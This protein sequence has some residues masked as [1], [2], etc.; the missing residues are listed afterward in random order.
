MSTTHRM[1][2]MNTTDR[3]RYNLVYVEQIHRYLVNFG[4][5]NEEAAE[6][7][8]CQSSR[9]QSVDEMRGKFQGTDKQ[10]QLLKDAAPGAVHASHAT[11]IFLSAW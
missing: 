3:I 1:T 8:Y 2:G 10:W 11:S 9:K 4:L 7:I 5:S 6:F